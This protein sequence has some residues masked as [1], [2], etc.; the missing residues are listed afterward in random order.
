MLSNIFARFGSPEQLVSDNGSNFTSEEFARFCKSNGIEH[1]RS[2]PHHP[3]SNGQAERF[4]DSF[5]RSLKKMENE[6]NFNENLQVFLQTYRTTPNVIC[7]L[8]KSPAESFLGRK[9]RTTFD[10]LFPPDNK[11][12]TR[13][14]KMEN[15]FNSKHGSI[16]R[17]FNINDPV[18]IQIHRN[19]NWKWEEGVIKE[20]VGD[21]NWIV[22][23]NDRRTQ[24]HT[25]QLRF[26]NT[27]DDNPLSIEI[28]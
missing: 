19:N 28:D 23:T 9:P 27:I 15:Q 16:F 2:S 6:R 25:N 24:A 5:K 26:R 1:L 18:W 12:I 20:K 10:L 14:V 3:M 22:E 11:I 17:S 8:N 21:V 4:V 13:N 7:P